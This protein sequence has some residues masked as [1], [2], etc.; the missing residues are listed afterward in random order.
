[1]NLNITVL[2]GLDCIFI[3]KIHYV[4]LNESA[5]FFGVYKVYSLPDLARF[6][7]LLLRVSLLIKIDFTFIFTDAT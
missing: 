1:M 4:D 5:I 7:K 2:Q 6:L 3:S